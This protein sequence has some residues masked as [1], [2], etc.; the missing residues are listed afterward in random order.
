M[1]SIR[2]FFYSS[3][4]IVLRRPGHGDLVWTSYTKQFEGEVWLAIVVLM[5]TLTIF[6]YLAMR[7]SSNEDPIS[8]SEAVLITFGFLC[9]QGKFS[10]GLYLR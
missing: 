4:Q 7:L 9:G 6:L 2:I 3:F 8:P 1:V 5:T 10:I